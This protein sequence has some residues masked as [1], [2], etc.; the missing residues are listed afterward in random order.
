MEHPSGDLVSIVIPTLD[1]AGPLRRALASAMGQALPGEL[2]VEIVVVDNSAART[3]EQTVRAFAAD[4][5]VRYVSAP[6]PG[7]ANA[8]NAGVK[9]ANGRW[10]AFLDD[11]EEASAD[12]LAHHVAALTQTGADASFGP[13]EARGEEG[14][15]PGAF[16]AFFSRRIERPDHGD[17]SDL[18][19]LLGTNN[20]VFSR[21]RC[22]G[23]DE[24]FDVSLNETGGEDSLLLRQLVE[25]G[26]KFVWAAE[27]G[28]VE[29]VP[30]R[31]ARWDYV[32]RRR[33]LSGQIRT[34][35]H[36]RL[37]PPRWGGIAFW[38]AA[39][40]VQAGGWSAASLLLRP[41]DLE[42]AELARSRAWGGLGKLFWGRRFGPRLYG[43]GLVS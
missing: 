9:A 19:A 13:V 43:A 6:V 22:L 14:E 7:V 30:P 34:F 28:V 4:G 35:V 23:G 33:F 15:L 20:S 3:A 1:R 38:M 27:A 31:R 2:A 40:A 21:A 10:I 36:R 26:R 12:W 42:K 18:A 5:R 41:F 16:A 32:R 11:D 25:S 37:S 17:I 39:G 8:R 29:W 24:V